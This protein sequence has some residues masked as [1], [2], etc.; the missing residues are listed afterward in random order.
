MDRAPAA[1][2]MS[3]SPPARRQNPT[4][5][6]LREITTQYEGKPLPMKVLRTDANGVEQTLTVTVK[7]RREPGTDRVVIGFLPTLDA[8]HA[9]VAKDHGD[10]NG[11]AALD[12]PR[13][14]RIVSVNQKAGVQ[15][16]RR[17]RR[18][19]A[20]ARTAGHPAIPAR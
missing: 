9:V 16:L 8:R 17:H 15:L 7:P 14:A 5:K 6:E 13:G 10:G 3:F 12:I 19:A 20:V 18:G 4:Y 11:P 2:A 1:P